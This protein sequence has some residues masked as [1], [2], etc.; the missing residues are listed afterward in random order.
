MNIELRRA[1]RVAWIGLAVLLPALL[2]LALNRRE[3]PAV[4]GSLPHALGDRGGPQDVPDW[5]DDD[6]FEGAQ[7]EA[8]GW[9]SAPTWVQLRVLEPLR[10]PDVLLYWTAARPASGLGDD[11]LFLGSV[12]GTSVERFD[13]VPQG[14]GF[15]VLYSLGHD[16]VVAVGSLP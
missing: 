12:R 7:I 5:R 14:D 2:G 9:H 11:A 4:M 6:R 10:R 3:A 1:H 8:S 16:E 15:L 13:G